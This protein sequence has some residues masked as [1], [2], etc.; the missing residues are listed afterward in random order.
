M[1]NGQYLKEVGKRIKKARK[2]RK[3]TLMQLSK[4]CGIHITQLSF[5]ENGKCNSHILTLK[6]IA[7]VLQIDIKAF[8]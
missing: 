7:D 2:A 8:L 1:S 4:S 6:S 5:L 3:I